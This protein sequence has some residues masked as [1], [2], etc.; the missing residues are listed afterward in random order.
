MK[1]AI[2]VAL[3]VASVTVAAAEDMKPNAGKDVCLLDNN[4][5]V[6]HSYYNIVDKIARIRAAIQL[7][8][9]VYTPQELEHLEYLLEEALDVADHIDAHSSQVPENRDR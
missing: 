1:T 8:T 7:G 6:G 4:N 2:V 9:K 3:L 5:C